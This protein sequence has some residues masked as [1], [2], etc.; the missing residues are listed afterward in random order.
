MKPR[1]VVIAGGRNLYD[2]GF[3]VAVMEAH[4]RE[5]DVVITGGACGVDQH[6]HEQA[7]AW[8]CKTEIVPA[9]WRDDDGEIDRSAG[10]KRN[11]HMAENCDV[12]LAIWNGESTGTR[13]MIEQALRCNREIHIYPYPA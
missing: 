6:A 11:A 2:R 8:G 5:T 4:L 1:R 9:Q 12:L 10:P 3:V 7:K 13:N